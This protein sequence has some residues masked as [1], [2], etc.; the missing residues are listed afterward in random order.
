MLCFMLQINIYIYI[1]ISEVKKC[2][3][4]DFFYVIKMTKFAMQVIPTSGKL[5][6]ELDTVSL[7]ASI[8]AKATQDSHPSKPM[9]FII[10]NCSTM[11]GLPDQFLNTLILKTQS[12]RSL[13]NQ[14]SNYLCCGTKFILCLQTF[15]A[16][17]LDWHISFTSHCSETVS[18]SNR[19]RCHFGTAYI[20]ILHW[21]D[22]S[23]CV[24]QLEFA[25]GF[26]CFLF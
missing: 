5:T 25:I 16:I 20:F 10:N 21:C 4:S 14:W 17:A 2:L 1:N 9:N 22:L 24:G 3:P 13:L 15:I 7:A 26:G 23:I 12:N 6:T 19:S 18:D 11:Y 8:Y